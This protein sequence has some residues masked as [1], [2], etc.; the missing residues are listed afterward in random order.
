[1]YQGLHSDLFLQ[2]EVDYRLQRAMA[3]VHPK[4]R[5]VRAQRHLPWRLHRNPSHRRPH[6]QPVAG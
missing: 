6:S 5:T 1:M 4:G 3:E 2:A